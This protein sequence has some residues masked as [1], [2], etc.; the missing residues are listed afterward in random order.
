MHHRHLMHIRTIDNPPKGS[1][2]PA[3]SETEDRPQEIDYQAKYEEALKHSREWEKRAKD[4][5]NAAEKLK[6]LEESQMSESQKAEAKARELEAKVAAFE[7]EKQRNEWRSQVAKETKVPAE[8]LHG[9]TL[10]E[11]QEHAKLLDSY[12]HP[13]PKGAPV[14]DPAGTPSGKP[15]DQERRDYVRKLFGE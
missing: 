9:S 13:K 12:L 11:M 7:T 15:A 14:K 4:N 8:L 2:E 6:Q 5:K 3:S 1:G 10:E